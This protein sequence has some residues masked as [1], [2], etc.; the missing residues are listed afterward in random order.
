MATTNIRAQ[1][2]KPIKL[3]FANKYFTFN[4]RG[5]E[6]ATVSSICKVDFM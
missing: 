3:F 2:S 4:K 1:R 6:Y 5:Y